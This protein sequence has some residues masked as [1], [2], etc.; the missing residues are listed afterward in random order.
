MAA[1]HG[2]RRLAFGGAGGTRAAGSSDADQRALSLGQ[3]QKPLKALRRP[4]RV[5]DGLRVASADERAVSDANGP[6]LQ[7]NGQRVPDSYG[8]IVRAELAQLCDFPTSLRRCKP[9]PGCDELRPRWRKPSRPN[10]AGTR[11]ATEPRGRS[12]PRDRSAGAMVAAGGCR[13]TRSNR[14]MSRRRRTQPRLHKA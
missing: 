11:S 9:A 12:L 2:G 6:H 10:V 1:R 14:A 8:A 5:L 4:Y 7:T 3:V 13:R